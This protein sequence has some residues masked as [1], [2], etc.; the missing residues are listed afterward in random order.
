[1]KR[2]STI[3]AMLLTIILVFG[4]ILYYPSLAASD[5]PSTASSITNS[6]H[7]FVLF[8]DISETPGYLHRSSSPWSGWEGDIM[9]SANTALSK[10]FTDPNWG[11][12]GTYDDGW[13]SSRGQYAMNLAF[14][15]Q[16]TNDSRYLSKAKEALLNLN[17]APKPSQTLM[18]TPEGFEAIGLYGYCLAYDWIQ[19]SLDISSDDLIRDKLAKLADTVHSNLNSSTVNP[20]YNYK[21]KI[22]YYDYMGQAYPIMGIAGVTLNDYTNPNHLPLSSTP[23]DWIKVG[24]DCFFINDELHNFNRSMISFGFDN[25]GKDLIGAYKMYYIDDLALWAQVYSHYYGKNMFDVYPIARLA[26]TSEVWDSLP[27]QY[28]GDFVT[29]GNIKYSYHRGVANLLDSDNRSYVLSHDDIIDNSDLLQY[30]RSSVHIYYR[31]MLPSALLYIVYGDYSSTPRK[32]PPWTSHL[33]A[34]SQ[35]QVFRGNWNADSDWLSFTTWDVF[36]AA[37]RNMAHNDQLGFEYY[38]RGD[39]LLADGGEDRE[40]LDKYYGQ[41]EVYHNTIAIEDPR[42]PFARSSWADSTSRGIFKGFYYLR[43]P[44]T[45]NNIVNTSWIE[46]VDSSVT[47]NS[48]NTYEGGASESMQLSSPIQYDRAV[49]Y[50]QKDYF[51]VIDRMEGSQTWGYR[52]IFRPTSLNIVPSTGTTESQVGYVVGSLTIGNTSYNWLSKPYKKEQQTGI[53]TNSIEWDTT[54]PYGNNVNLQVFTV[55]SSEVLVTKHVGR[56][57]G[58]SE[59]SEVFSPAVYFRSPPANNVYRATVMLSKYSN[60]SQ[61]TP[62]ALSVSGTGNALMVTSPTYVDYIYTGKGASSFA[63]YSTDADTVFARNAGQPIEYTLMGGTYIN[64]ADVPLVTVSSR[65]DYLTLKK[66]GNG[67]TFAVKSRGDI[68]ITLSQIDPASSYKVTRD[69]MPYTNWAISGNTMKIVTGSNEHRFDVVP[70]SG[71]P[72]PTL[73]PTAPPTPN[74]SAAP[75]PT[76][77]AMAS[78]TPTAIPS[79]T[80]TPKAS[81]TTASKAIAVPGANSTSMPPASVTPQPSPGLELLAALAA[82]GMALAVRKH[83]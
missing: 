41:Y 18:M 29:N 78:P 4:Q 52:N 62:R 76:P 64:F 57:A 14:A 46:I 45:I 1:M 48:V 59:K 82:M 10:D 3:I 70:T 20:E 40:V 80:P 65:V 67:F 11:T 17:K 56:I 28:S 47:I 26:L 33:D 21:D 8:H 22:Y 30:S 66:Q 27:N 50:P 60:E 75:T 35:L 44:A 36:A 12:S 16:I 63:S 25:S 81:P 15:Y 54:N 39:L 49:L 68:N 61:K 13:V 42:S 32:S 69:G 6:T 38:S 34:N 74:P 19:P 53:T 77:T 73:T 37:S 55:P 31:S 43:T 72:T 71:T 83:K 79:V 24:T 51:I 7:P 58:Y 9:S 23:A 2:K 5:L